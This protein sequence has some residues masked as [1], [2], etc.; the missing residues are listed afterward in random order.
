MGLAMNQPPDTS[1][2]ITGNDVP[3]DPRRAAAMLEQATQQ[4]RRTFAV[5]SSAL[6]AFR[7]VLVLVAFG[8]FWL[9]VRG[10]VPY[11]GP[12]GVALPV[13][14]ALVGIN[15]G[16]SA[17]ALRRASAGV[18]GPA[19]RKRHAWGVVMLA[20][21]VAAYVLTIPLFHVGAS[22]PVWG[23]YPASAPMLIV[24]LAGAVIA[25]ALRYWPTAGTLAAIGIVA[26]VAGFGGP[27]G[28]WL[29][30]GIGMCAVC[31]A[32]AGFIAWQRRRSVF[33]P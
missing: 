28:A 7:A 1:E 10:Q 11:S 19:Q 17:W 18:S 9:S 14:F 6:W 16:W 30:M 24:G 27:V 15:V 29:I 8:G 2:T 25:A 33:G 21:L 26:V 20:I 31:L 22:H 4:A 3:L 23:L 32:T 13:A 12:S 5:G